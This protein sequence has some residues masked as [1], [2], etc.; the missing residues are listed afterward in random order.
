MNSKINIKGVAS[1]KIQK[2][3]G[4]VFEKTIDNIVVT[5][6][7]EFFAKKIFDNNLNQRI[8]KIGIGANGTE[9]VATDTFTSFVSSNGATP[10]IKEIETQNSFLDSNTLNYVTNFFDTSTDTLGD[11]Q[12]IKELALIALDEGTPEE[13]ILLCRTTF[14]DNGQFLKEASDI[15]TVT[16]RITIN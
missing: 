5:T 11:G 14:E 6:G 10:I 3:N 2:K 15:V 8:A 9:Q 13:D 16:W 4:D 12:A 1:I 7:K